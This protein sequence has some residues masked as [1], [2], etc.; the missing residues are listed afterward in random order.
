MAA[1]ATR[2]AAPKIQSTRNYRLFQR[3]D[4]N[5]ALDIKRH[6][7]LRDSMKKYGFLPYFPIVCVRDAN[8]HLVVKEGQHRLAIA[9]SLGLAVHYVVADIEFDIAEI[10]CTPIVWRPRDYAEKFAA[11]GRAAYQDGIDFAD[12]HGIPVGLAFSLLAGTVSF[13][14]IAAQFFMGDFKIRDRKWADAVASAYVP[15]VTLERRLRGARFL[16]ACM[17]VCRIESFDQ[18]RLLANASRCREKLVPYSTADA[19]IGMLEDIYNFGQRKLVGLKAESEM[20]MRNRNVIGD[21]NGKPKA[22]K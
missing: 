10:N 5:R 11:N 18:K 19:Y 2:N 22:K 20:A 3:S 8:K 12:K 13:T 16:L 17:R 15:M 21:R 1:T 9:E 6:K 7:K 4:E 14:N